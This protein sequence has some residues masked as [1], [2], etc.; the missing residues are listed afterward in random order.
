MRV[1]VVLDY[2]YFVIHLFHPRTGYYRLDKLWEDGSNNV[3]L[4]FL[5]EDKA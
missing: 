5:G 4:Y 1:W 2:N 3:E